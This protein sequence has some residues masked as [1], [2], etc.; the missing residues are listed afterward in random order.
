M[1]TDGR[2]RY[3]RNTQQMVLVEDVKPWDTDIFCLPAVHR[4]NPYY[5]MGVVYLWSAGTGQKQL[6]KTPAYA[7]L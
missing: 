5:L 7:A 1:L 2:H 6:R 3:S 4:K